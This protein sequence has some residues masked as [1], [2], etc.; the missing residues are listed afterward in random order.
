MTKLET[1]TKDLQKAVKRLE[2][3]LGMEKTT[4]VRDSAIQRFEFCLDL[5]WKTLKTYLEDQKGVVCKSPKDCFRQGYKHGL[6]QYDDKWIELVDLR[7]E[8]VHT[9]K[10][11]LAEDTYN[12]LPEALILLQSLLKI[13]ES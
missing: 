8:T 7:N 1:Q 5:A 6:L 3:V 12:Q 13:L 9:Y 2:E 10:E 11:E 4:V